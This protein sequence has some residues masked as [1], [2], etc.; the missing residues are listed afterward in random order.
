[1]EDKNEAAVE[2]LDRVETNASDLKAGLRTGA[3]KTAKVKNVAFADAVVKDN[4]KPWSTS[5]LKLYAVRLL[6][7]A[8][9]DSVPFFL[10]C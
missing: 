3:V 7:L 5:M 4:P 10:K 8:R 2:Q 1:M 6:S 9:V